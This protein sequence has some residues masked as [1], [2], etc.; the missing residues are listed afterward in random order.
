M[1]QFSSNDNKK[2][3]RPID[4]DFL[5]ESVMADLPKGK[6]ELFIGGKNKKMSTL[7]ESIK[8]RNQSRAKKTR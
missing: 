8:S 1:S 3:R 4:I 5:L 6:V 7:K 2:P